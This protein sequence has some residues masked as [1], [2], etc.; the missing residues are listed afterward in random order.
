MGVT[1]VDRGLPD[2]RPGTVNTTGPKFTPSFCSPIITLFTYFSHH[3]GRRRSLLDMTATLRDRVD[4]KYGQAA[5][6]TLELVG[7]AVVDDA[8]ILQEADARRY[9]YREQP[10]HGTGLCDGSSTSRT[11][12]VCLP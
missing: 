3:G 8:G 2:L 11:R 9:L 6:E 4:P 12:S 10:Q 7:C 5:H 1:G